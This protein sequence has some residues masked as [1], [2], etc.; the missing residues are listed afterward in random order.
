MNLITGD[1]HGGIDIHKLGSA[2]FPFGK[3]LTRQDNLFIAGDAGLWFD[4][5]NEE[6]Y[7]QIWLT[8]KP[9]TTLI[10]DGNHENFDYM[11]T[12]PKGEW[13]G[14]KVN[15]LADNIL[16]LRRGEVYDIFGYK[17]FVFGGALSID[18]AQRIPGK[19]WWG[20]E[21]PNNAEFENAMTNLEKHNWKVDYV[22]THTCPHME[23]GSFTDNLVRIEDPT[24]YMLQEIKDRID[25]KTW[26]F[27]HFHKDK[28]I[29]RFRCLF[30]D[31]HQIL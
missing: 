30:Q 9:W 4:Y 11:E 15:Y 3:R 21:I 27:G 13:N 24:S 8:Q 2:A 12:F 17:Y 6:A 16:W 23:I 1:I 19:S 7:W 25:F 29:G 5:S 18:K 22:I 14:G 31:I 10:I 26:F 28:A 20:Q